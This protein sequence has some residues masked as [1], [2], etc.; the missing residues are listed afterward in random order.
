MLTSSVALMVAFALMIA[1]DYFSFRSGLVRDLRTL[2]DV[3]GTE[4][5][6]ALDF[7]D[8][9]FATKALTGLVA[10]PNITTAAIYT[11][12]GKIFASYL[13]NNQSEPPP[14]KPGAEGYVFKNA[15]LTLFRS[16]YLTLFQ[17]IMRD[18]ERIGIVYLQYSL[19]EMTA[20][21]ARYSAIAAAIVLGASLIAF[22]FSSRLQ[23]VISEPILSLAHTARI[24]SEEKNYSMRAEKRTGDEVG[25]LI[26]RFNEMLGQIEEHEKELQ[27][28]NEQLVQSEQ[29]ARAGTQ[30]KSQFLANMSHELRTPLNAII[31]YSEMLQEEAQD[32]G[33]E[34]FIPDLKKINRAGRHLLELI[35]DVLDLSK[36]EAGK[37]ELYLETFDIPSLLEEISATVQ[38]LVQKNSNTIEVRCSPNLGAMR[39]D[40]T[41]VRQALFNL[42]SNASKFTNHGKIT[43][44]AARE[45]SPSNGDWIVFRVSDTGIGMTPEQQARVFETFAQAEAST[46]RD[47]GGTGLGLAITRNF[48]RMMGGDVSLTSEPGKG[49]IF[50]IRLPIEIHEPE[51]ESEVESKSIA[52]PPPME[53]KTVLVIDDDA[54]TREV[55]ERFLNRK[56]FH[57]EC[58]SSGQDG[59]R[60]AKELHPAAITLD[61]MMP[62]MDGWAVLST[63]KSEPELADI[64][65]VMLTIVD[66]KN[67]GYSLGATDYMIKPV[68]RERLAEILMK[69]RDVPPPRC[70]LV[71]DDEEPARQ[72]LTRLLEKE[73]WNVLQAED[74]LAALERMKKQ[75]PDLILLDLMMPKM[76]GFEFV[77]ELHKHDEWQSIPIIVI[78]AGD[79]TIQDR[80]RLDGYV[81]KVLRKSAL[82]ED[83]L[84]GEIR[85]LISVCVQRKQQ[86]QHKPA[87]LASTA[88]P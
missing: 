40:M 6:S 9:E 25:F 5:S 49:S 52:A 53:G 71:I 63:L 10:T 1:S 35:N 82:S 58:A 8:A 50:T 2:A 56:G 78:T 31:G 75:R 13:R 76:N 15:Y 65:V 32:S 24:V 64:P 69:F 43:L 37:M 54:D 67:L 85:D 22:L 86:S 29:R 42:L 38:L 81:E 18:G 41:K 19:Q 84:L 39:A 88:Q 59:L 70:A 20:R 27:N 12:E 33:Q 14:T 74:G 44:E 47:F 26:D 55:L 16:G 66:D 11:K 61:V 77:A 23:R 87:G 72:M 68:D 79:V 60:L 36:I 83:A 80:V 46:M 7:D 30:A 28:V 17:P 34:S 51:A 57:V 21:L 4:S 62:G 48:C 45:A 3:M 73:G